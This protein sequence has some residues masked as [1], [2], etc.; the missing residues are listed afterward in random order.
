MTKLG[1][2]NLTK[3]GV[4]GILHPWVDGRARCGFKRSQE[5]LLLNV[6]HA[7][8]RSLTVII[9]TENIL[10][11]TR[12]KWMIARFVKQDEERRQ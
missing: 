10:R 4:K 7:A 5:F 6:V 2:G 11:R 1:G 12:K 8:H 9:R 3:L